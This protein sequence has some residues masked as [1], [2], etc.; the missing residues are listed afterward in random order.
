MPGGT[1]ITIDAFIGA[2]IGYRDFN[3]EFPEVESFEGLF[4]E[5]DTDELS[6]PFR[7]GINIGFMLEAR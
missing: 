3:R 2:G 4:D 1:G 7:F 5:L 6:I